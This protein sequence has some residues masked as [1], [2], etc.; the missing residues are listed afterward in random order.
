MQKALSDSEVRDGTTVDLS[1]V[2]PCYN[3]EDGLAQLHRRVDSVCTSTSDSYELVL[4]NDG[5]TDSSWE[6]MNALADQ[7]PNLVLVNLSRN[8]GQQLALLAGLR[9]ARGSRVLVIDADLQDPPELLPEMMEVMDQ[10]ADVVYGRRRARPGN[11]F[12]YLVTAAAFYRLLERMTGGL[13]PPDSGEFRLI[14]R[15][16]L[17]IFLAMPERH[18]YTRGMISWIGFRQE[19]VY[20]D[21]HRRFS[22]TTKFPLRKTIRVAV[23]AITAL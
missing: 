2:I 9:V 19:A 20:Y 14:S 16:V 13:V 12:L 22:G 5:S 15:R 1:I 18:R 6:V 17:D 8:F 7:N 10:G 3:E 21:R 4:V 11:R 23:D